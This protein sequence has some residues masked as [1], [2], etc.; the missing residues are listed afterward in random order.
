MLGKMT[1]NGEKDTLSQ[2][3]IRLSTGTGTGSVTKN[4]K[5]VEK[6]RALVGK[7]CIKG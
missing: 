7:R 5:H 2:T 4:C 6:K 1:Q 3:K